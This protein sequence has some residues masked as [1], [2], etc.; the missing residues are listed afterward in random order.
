M[1]FEIKNDDINDDD[2]PF[3]NIINHNFFFYCP[4]LRKSTTTMQNKMIAISEITEIT[5]ISVVFNT[6]ASSGFSVDAMIFL[7]DSDT[8]MFSVLF[9]VSIMIFVVIFDLRL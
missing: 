3:L 2:V 6:A 5:P 4:F 1:Y 8:V 7:P 9:V